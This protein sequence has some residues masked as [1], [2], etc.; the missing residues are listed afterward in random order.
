MLSLRTVPGRDEKP[1]RRC[2]PM[3]TVSACMP[4]CA[5]VRISAR[6]SN[7]CAATSPALRAR[8]A[9]WNA[10]RQPAR[11]RSPT[12]GSSALSL[13]MSCRNSRAP[14]EDPRTSVLPARAPPR[15]PARRWPFSR[16]PDP[17]LA[18]NGSSTALTIPP[19][20]RSREALKVRRSPPPRDDGETNCPRGRVLTKRRA[21]HRF[22]AGDIVAIKKSGFNFLSP[23]V[24]PPVVRN[25]SIWAPQ[26]KPD[27]GGG[28]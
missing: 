13:V 3:R 25:Y 21:I 16:R 4:G 11:P 1:R 10:W 23:A 6:N 17:Q 19:G 24:H 7:G 9:Q 12:N 5:V 22:P 14:G 2:A 8:P 26:A 20:P 18:Y 27:S 15:S 28:W